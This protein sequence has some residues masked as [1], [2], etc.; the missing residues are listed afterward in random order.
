MMGRGLSVMVGIACTILIAGAVYLGGDLIAPVA[1]ALFIMALVWPLQAALQRRLPQLLALFL[2]LGVTLIVLAGL[3]SLTL[4]GF[5]KAAQWLIASAGRFQAL[6]AEAAGWLEGHGLVIAGS[7][8]ETFNVGWMIRF[9]QSVAARVNGMLG[10]A[11]LT[12]I[13]V[14][15]GLL[16]V[17]VIRAKLAAGEAGENGRR[18][19]TAC[20]ETAA[21]LRRYMGVRT[22]VSLCTGV[23]VWG[24][25]TLAGLDLAVAWG[26]IAFVLNY[27]PFIGPLLATL[28]PT[29]FTMAQFES[30][31]MAVAVFAGMNLIQFLS[32]SYIEP[33]IAGRALAVSPF[34]VLL[35]VFV[36]AFMWG[37]AGA[38]IGVPVVIAALTLCAQY[39]GS[40]WVARLL[41]GEPPAT[42]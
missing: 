35:A 42:T 20:S 17:D 26:V 23:A 31:Q 40:R 22:V 39:D 21:K 9:L 5:G 33:R 34:I 14:M 10:F 38:F 19:L 6:Y 24:F 16:E 37:L 1:F 3:F 18:L 4:W 13:Y 2:T 25:A 15:L 41:S 8:V 30:W 11:V 32:G 27:I 12:G 7:I 29:L 28:M 36:G